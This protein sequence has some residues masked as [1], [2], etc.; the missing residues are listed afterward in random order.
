LSRIAKNLE[1]LLAITVQLP[2]AFARIREA[3]AETVLRI[4][5]WR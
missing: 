4:P 5:P 3:D 2:Q 1:G